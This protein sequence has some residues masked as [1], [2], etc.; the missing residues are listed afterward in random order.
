MAAGKPK[1]VSHDEVG[2]I[3]DK[4][5]F[6]QKLTQAILRLN[7]RLRASDLSEAGLSDRD[8]LN[9]IAT[10][11]AQ[12]SPISTIHPVAGQ[13]S[14][15][16]HLNKVH[17][18]AAVVCY[19]YVLAQPVIV[20]AVDADRLGQAEAIRLAK[21]FDDIVLEALDVTGK[22]GRTRL[23]V[24]GIILFIFF[25]HALATTF[26]ERTQKRCKIWHF[27]KKTWVVPWVVDVSNNTVTSHTGLPF[28]PGVLSRDSLQKEIFQ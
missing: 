6:Y 24:T 22:L 8:D 3:V 5:A 20:A 9:S 16:Q 18:W 25:D 14:M 11:A 2:Q 15:Q 17:E 10:T 7:F 28:L 27:F 23:S 4:K 19:K 26:I 12:L 21:Q 13:E 1:P